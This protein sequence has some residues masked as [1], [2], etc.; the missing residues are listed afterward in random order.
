[1]EQIFPE[2]LIELLTISITFSFIL[3]ILIQKFKSLKCINHSWI[4]WILNLLFSFLVGIPFSLH[5]YDI[6]I[7]DSIWVGFFSFIGAAS[8]YQA[9]KNQ[10]I[11][12]YKPNSVKDDEVKI[13]TENEIVRD[14]V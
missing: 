5:F 9:L 8:I 14:D 7:K 1:M 6:S 10:T 11:I 3:M 4:I 12:N 13:K 2:L